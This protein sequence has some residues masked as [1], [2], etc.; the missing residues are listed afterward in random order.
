VNGWLADPLVVVTVRGPVVAPSGT[1][2]VRVV[3]VS[4]LT[5]ALTPLKATWVE[6]SSKFVP[7]TVT[8]LRTGPLDGS[9]AVIVRAAVMTV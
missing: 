5:T 1:V 3:L 2:V 4:E 7:L 8:K 9:S 6:P